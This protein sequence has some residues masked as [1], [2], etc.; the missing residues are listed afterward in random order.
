M[1][2]FDYLVDG[3]KAIDIVGMC[4]GVSMGQVCLFTP[5][6]G[7]YFSIVCGVVGEWYL[8]ESFFIYNSFYDRG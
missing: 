5:C 7:Q 3:V 1:D 2:P 6:C 4:C 8:P